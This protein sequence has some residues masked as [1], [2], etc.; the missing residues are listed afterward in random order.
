MRIIDISHT[1]DENTPLYPGDH[2]LTITRYA[3][4]EQDKYTSYILTSGMHTGTHVDIPM[5]LVADD[6]MVSDFPPD[7]F[8]GRGALL[9]VR[10][11][12]QIAMK[13][14]SRELVREGDIVLLYTGCDGKY[15]TGEYFTSHPAVSA[16][17]G[18][19]LLSRRI[20]MLGMD[21]PAPDYPPFVFHRALLSKGIFVLENLANLG[22][23]LNAGDF[24]VIA[25]PLKIAAE[26]SLVRAICRVA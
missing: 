20:K 24:E 3:E 22:S 11:E 26:A 16:E 25:L 4:L 9:D 17:L 8:I 10:R 19:F 2:A 1:L 23:L 12:E 15:H 6:R 5:H 13:P 21:M 14:A 18:D 7:C